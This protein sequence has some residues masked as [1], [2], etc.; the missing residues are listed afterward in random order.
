M[1]TLMPASYKDFIKDLA[2]LHTAE[3]MFMELYRLVALHLY[4]G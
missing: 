2:F 3:P 1:G 4:M